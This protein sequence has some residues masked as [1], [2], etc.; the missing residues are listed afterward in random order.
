MQV[1]PTAPSPTV[2]HLINLD[3]LIVMFKFVVLEDKDSPNESC[4]NAG[5]SWEVCDV[6]VEEERQGRE[7]KKKG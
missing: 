3:A 1:L 6:H 2:T 7:R 5:S 4:G